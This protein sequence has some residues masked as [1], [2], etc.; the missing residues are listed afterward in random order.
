MSKTLEIV[1]IVL[2]GLLLLI[3]IFLAGLFMVAKNLADDVIV[4]TPEE[5][6][7]WVEEENK[8]YEGSDLSGFNAVTVDNEAVTSDFFID[9]KITMINL[10]TT[11]CS[12]CIDEMPE[13]EKAYQ[14]RPEWLNVLSICVDASDGEHELKLAKKIAK[15]EGLT[16]KVIVPDAVLRSVLTEKTTV[17][18]TT[19]FVDS[20]GKMVGGIYSGSS[21]YEDFLSEAKIR[22]DLIN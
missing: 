5:E 3:L 1:L 15:K 12:S 2:G 11:D 20:S 16:F 4:M 18:P 13:L 6:A 9:Y 14:N 10:W 21:R 19:I 17:F 7:A 22:L 8:K